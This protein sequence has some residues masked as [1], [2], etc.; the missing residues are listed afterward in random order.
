MAAEVPVQNSPIEIL[1]SEWERVVGN[2]TAGRERI[3]LNGAQM[4]VTTIQASEQTSAD[5]VWD[6]LFHQKG[7][8]TEPGSSLISQKETEKLYGRLPGKR[9]E[10]YLAKYEGREVLGV[11][12][13]NAN[14]QLGAF[15]VKDGEVFTPDKS[16]AGHFDVVG[17]T[18]QEWTTISVEF[19]D[20]KAEKPDVLKELTIGLSMPLILKDSQVVSLEEII[21]DPRLTADLRNVVDFGAGKKLPPDFW[22]LLRRLLPAT[23]VAGRRLADGRPVVIRREGAMN[24]EEIKR[25]QEIIKN[26]D[27]GGYLRLDVRGSAPRLAFVGKLPLQRIPV[28]G[29]GFDK[30]R[31]LIVVAVDGRQEGSAGATISELAQIMRFEGAVTAGL[32]CA[33]GDVT[34]VLKTKD[35]KFEILNS[36]SNTNKEGNRVTRLEPSQLILG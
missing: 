2:C 8:V 30:E 4:R 9:P 25:F 7:I 31:K 6:P 14:W 29:V 16:L 20:G 1:S 23:E 5:L 32:G 34:V 28:I 24:D 18:G 10:E 35:E 13:S 19:K 22:L 3:M 11:C 21:G 15:L 17:L 26:D 27:L 36:P 12:P 33:G